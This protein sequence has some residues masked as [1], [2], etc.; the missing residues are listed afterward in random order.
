MRLMTYNLLNGGVG[1]TDPL[2]EVIRHVAPDVVACPEADSRKNFELL[3]DRLGME[4]YWAEAADKHAVG[5]LSRLPILSATNHRGEPLR[6]TCAEVRVRLAAGGE[7]T[8]I[9]AHLAARI[10]RQQEEVRATE[11]DA[12]LALSG[13][14][15][16]AG[17]PHVIAGDFNASHPSQSIEPAALRP[18]DRSDLAAQNDVV[19]R[20][21]IPRILEAGYLDAYDA[22]HGSDAGATLSTRQPSLR[23]DYIFLSQQMGATLR[24]CN[25]HHERLARFASDHY[26]VWAEL[27]C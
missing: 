4:R 24:A 19:A 21:A 6:R 25:V 3:A 22:L 15:R 16:A 20:L 17:A 27:D 7:L 12:I 11:T 1:R 10:T 26:P 13:P 23:V 14:L 2:A 8:V 5:V 18:R 9:A